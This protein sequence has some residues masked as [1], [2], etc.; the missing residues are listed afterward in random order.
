MFNE[1]P[2]FSPLIPENSVVFR[3][4][5]ALETEITAGSLSLN[6]LTVLSDAAKGLACS[7]LQ[8]RDDSDPQQFPALKAQSAA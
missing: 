2:A 1:S 7:S 6:I 8:W 5:F 4:L 3:D